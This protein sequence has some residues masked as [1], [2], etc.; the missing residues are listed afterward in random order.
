[1]VLGRLHAILDEQGFLRNVPA[2]PRNHLDSARLVASS[3]ERVT[4]WEVHCIT[5]ALRHVETEFIL[6][7]GAAYVF[8]QLPLSRGRLHSDVD[9]L[10]SK[11]KLQVVESALL[12]S[13]W[14]HVKLEKYDQRI[15]RQFGHELPPLY[16]PERETVLD[17]HHN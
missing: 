2:A 7:K 13:G 12:S 3:Q 6:L 15:Y 5:R 1:A 16:H 9:I 11:D 8:S 4:R 14:V 10:V 17:V